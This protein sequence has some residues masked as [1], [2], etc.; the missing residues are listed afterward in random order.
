MP[1]AHDL[2]SESGQRGGRDHGLVVVAVAGLL[3]AAFACEEDNPFRNTPS[4]VVFDVSQVWDL[5]L[6][7]FPSAWDFPN[8]ERLFIGE[9]G[10]SSV[11]GNWV[12]DSRVDGTLILRPFSSLIDFT[13]IRTGIQDLGPLDFD[14]VVEVPEVGYSAAD[15]STG[16]PVI[17]GHVYAFRI[18]QLQFGLVPINY[19]KLGVLEVGTEF[20]DDPRSRYI[21]FE[22]SYQT[23]PLNRR[24]VEE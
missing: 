8:A 3:L 20:P 18:S 22:G 21:R 10:F 1:R 7:G 19:A 23:Q 2:S 5:G 16:V 13:F 14:A 9:G 17:E 15:D 12:L 6:A 11:R 24:V 4:Q